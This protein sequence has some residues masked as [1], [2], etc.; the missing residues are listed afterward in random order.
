VDKARIKEKTRTA[1]DEVGSDY[2]S[3]YWFSRA[4]ELRTGL[5]EK[6]LEKVKKETKKPKILDLC[7][8]TGHLVNELSEL[9]SYTGLDFA[10]SMIEHCSVTY[11]KE[12]FICGDA[13]ELPFKENTFDAVICF[14]SFHHILYPDKVLDEIKRVLKPGGFVLIA[15]FKDVK[16]NFAAKLG[17]VAS[18]KYYGYT[19]KRYSKSSMKKLME[20]RFKNLDIEI[21]P[22][23]RNLLKLLGI[24]FL[25]ASGRK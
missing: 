7:C 20:P 11:P 10:P 15:T 12:K 5:T 4:K 21:Y 22:D 13:E 6:V 19:T 23:G 3:W 25:I 2:D 8:G 18:S 1:Y 9:G 16:F 14:W 17:D 24:R